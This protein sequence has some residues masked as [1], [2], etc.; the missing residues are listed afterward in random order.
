M[1]LLQQLK[2]NFSKV[3]ENVPKVY[4]A[5]Y[6][7][8]KSEANTEEIYENGYNKALEDFFKD[9]QE[10]GKRIDYSYAFYNWKYVSEWLRH[11]PY[12][13]LSKV[14]FFSNTFYKVYDEIDLASF[15]EENGI[16]FNTSNMTGTVN[17]MFSSC[18]F[19][20][21][22]EISVVKSL[23][24]AQTQ[25]IL[26]CHKL[27]TIDRIIFSD[28]GNQKLNTA[29]F[30]FIQNCQLLKE[31]RFSGSAS[32]GLRIKGCPI[33]SRESI[34]SFLQICNVNDGTSRTVTLPKTCTENKVSTEEFIG[35]D[36]ELSSALAI[37]NENGY[38]VVFSD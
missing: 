36:E 35:Q 10:D 38:T 9:F 8:G 11:L 18:Y 19:T 15:F 22:P 28:T 7:K 29:N 1:D 14:Q 20:R 21:I 3:A 4:Q 16:I 37:A 30:G 26:N 5:G 27:H 12:K 2:S 17:Q 13:D 23:T 34:L 25:M 33:L 24:N 31:V 6:D 32:N